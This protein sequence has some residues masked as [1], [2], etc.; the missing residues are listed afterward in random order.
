MRTTKISCK[1]GFLLL[2]VVMMP[3]LAR[4]QPIEITPSEF[5][6]NLG[7][8]VIHKIFGHD[9]ENYFVLKYYG[10]QYHLEKLDHNLNFIREE[11]LKLYEGIKTYDLETIVHFHGE[12][13]L[14]ASHRKFAET[15]LMVQ[16]I[17]KETLLPA[18]EFTVMATVKFI[19]GNWA[20]FHFALSRH[21][22]KLMIAGQIK[23]TWE[24]VLHNEFFV[25][26]KGMELLWGKKDY[27][28][29]TGQGPR[30]SKFVVDEQGNVSILSLTKRESIISFFQASAAARFPARPRPFRR[31]P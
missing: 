22:T 4:T 6:F 31:Y 1:T 12:L 9:A 13:F 21:E 20:D 28:D 15:D 18:T 30:E 16:K 5:N 26:D 24:K 11:P 2:F 14:F 3:G 8:T 19:R 7:S 27:F 29:F 25:F 23:L 10:G 17:N